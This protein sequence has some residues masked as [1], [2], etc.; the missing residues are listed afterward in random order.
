M[1][2]QAEDVG[3]NL[4]S[5]TNIDDL[6]ETVAVPVRLLRKLVEDEPGDYAVREAKALLP[7]RRIVAV[8][9]DGSNLSSV[10]L[11]TLPDLLTLLDS[12]LDDEVISPGLRASIRHAFCAAL[13]VTE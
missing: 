9:D 4:P 11:A 6:P 5:M 1:R 8:E 2:R 12:V 10:Y 3:T 7:R 13:E